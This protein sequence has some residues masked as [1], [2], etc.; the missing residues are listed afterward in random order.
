MRLIGLPYTV[1]IGNRHDARNMEVHERDSG[2]TFTCTA[3]ELA[4]LASMSPYHD[5]E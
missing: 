2:K 1:V 5:H 3:D 4:E